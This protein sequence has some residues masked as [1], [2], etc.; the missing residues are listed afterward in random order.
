MLDKDL[1][2]GD[3]L[4]GAVHEL[5]LVAV[6]QELEIR[7]RSNEPGEARDLENPSAALRACAGDASSTARPLDDD[8]GVDDEDGTLRTTAFVAS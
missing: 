3:D 5:V 6:V 8:S 1:V 4:V 7:A 2:G